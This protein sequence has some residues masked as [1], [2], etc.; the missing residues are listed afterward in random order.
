MAE[1]NHLTSELITALSTK[2]LDE[3]FELATETECLS[4]VASIDECDIYTDSPFDVF[5]ASCNYELI[6]INEDVDLPIDYV[7]KF[8][9]CHKDKFNFL[10]SYLTIAVNTNSTIDKLLTIQ[11]PKYLDNIMYK[12]ATSI[13]DTA[14]EKIQLLRQL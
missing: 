2:Y 6:V 5:I 4:D 7:C 1:I 12:K 8:T 13:L 9:P 3:C 11:I 10:V 14:Y